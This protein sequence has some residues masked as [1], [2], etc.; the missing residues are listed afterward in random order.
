MSKFAHTV[1]TMQAMEI[2]DSLTNWVTWIMI[3]VG[4]LL[5]WRWIAP[6]PT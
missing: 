1:K 5:S 2:R 6:P 3:D 4:I